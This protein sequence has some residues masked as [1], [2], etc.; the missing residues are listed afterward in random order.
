MDLTA[1]TARVAN[2]TGLDATTDATVITAWLNQAYQRVSGAFDWPW[3]LTNATMQTEADITTG[4]ATISAGATTGTLSSAPSGSVATNYMIQFTDQSDDWYI[5]TANTTPFTSFTINVPFVGTSNYTAGAYIIRR[6]FYSI[7]T[8]IDRIIDLRQSITDIQI[9]MIDPRDYDRILPDPQN[10]GTPVY[11]YL[12]G[13]TSA[14]VWQLG[15][16]PIPSAIINIQMR[17]YQKITELSSGSDTPLIPAKWHSILVFVALALYGYEYIDDT[18]LSEAKQKAE[19][20]LNEMIGN[21]SPTPDK[22][23]VVQPW[24]QRVARPPFGALR[25]PP[26]FPS[27]GWW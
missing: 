3:L 1:M 16:D 9:P 11:A 25:F 7:P 23:S 14:G 2:A 18:R 26:N 19:Q 13:M 27:N 24:D 17:G 4:T 10:T 5:I 22:M 8:T 12:T 6:V 15:F 21:N 20:M